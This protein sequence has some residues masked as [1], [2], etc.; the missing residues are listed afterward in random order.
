MNK[1]VLYNDD[2]NSFDGVILSLMEVLKHNVYQAEQCAV[3]VHKVG[4]CD[5]KVGSIKELEKYKK[6]LKDRGLK[7]KIE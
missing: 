6:E 2:V 3:I 5:I 7:I 4:K 1:L